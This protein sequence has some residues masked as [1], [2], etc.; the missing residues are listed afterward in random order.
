MGL[1]FQ[2]DREE[3]RRRSIERE[4]ERVRGRDKGKTKSRGGSGRISVLE[5]YKAAKDGK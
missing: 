4:K 3:D 5:K 2:I 1:G